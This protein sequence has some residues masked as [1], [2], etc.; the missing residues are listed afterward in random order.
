[1]EVCFLTMSLAAALIILR[2][3]NFFYLRAHSRVAS[4]KTYAFG[5]VRANA[6]WPIA[7]G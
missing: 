5:A 1:M 6:Y 2:A 4:Q 7:S 3:V